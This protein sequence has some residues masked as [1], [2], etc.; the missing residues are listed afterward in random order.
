M[1]FGFLTVYQITLIIYLIVII[2]VR[3]ISGVIFTT[4]EKVQISSELLVF[5]LNAN[6]IIFVIFW[7]ESFE[8]FGQVLVTL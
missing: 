4:C 2:R 5:L 7:Y 1:N 8:P 3:S 6:N